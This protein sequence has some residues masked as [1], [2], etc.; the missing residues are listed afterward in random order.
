MWTCF[1]HPRLYNLKECSAGCGNLVQQL[2]SQEGDLRLVPSTLFPAGTSSCDLYHAGVVQ[3]FRNGTWGSIC[4]Q[5]SANPRTPRI[6]E[7]FT[8]DAQV[9]CRQLGFS[10]G[11]VLNVPVA[12]ISPA[13]RAEFVVAVEVLLPSGCNHGVCIL[14]HQRC[15]PSMLPACMAFLT[16]HD[17][18]SDWAGS[19]L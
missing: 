9:I 16:A 18:G 5:T 12:D 10:F 3:I 4:P 2:P 6:D 15:K 1:G 13:D 8:V 11:T 7:E 14:C 19:P 17:R